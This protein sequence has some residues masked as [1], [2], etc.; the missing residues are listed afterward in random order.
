MY[1]IRII[2]SIQTTNINLYYLFSY[3]YKYTYL[4]TE[5]KT[6]FLRAPPIT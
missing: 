4:C 6:K 2:V 1:K 5:F 3:R